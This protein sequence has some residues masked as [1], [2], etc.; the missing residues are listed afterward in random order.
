MFCARQLHSKYNYSIQKKDERQHCQNILHIMLLWFVCSS[1][2]SSTCQ[3][4]TCHFGYSAFWRAFVKSKSKIL[5]RQRQ[6]ETE[7]MC[8]CVKNTCKMETIFNSTIYYFDVIWWWYGCFSHIFN[9]FLFVNIFALILKYI[10][11]NDNDNGNNKSR[12][13]I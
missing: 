9:A 11:N 12:A 4:L 6:K 13:K 8:V 1:F 5:E 10:N 3:R 7:R 2:L